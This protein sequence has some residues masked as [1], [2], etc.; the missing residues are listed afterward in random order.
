MLNNHKLTDLSTRLA[1]RRPPNPV[2]VLCKS[3]IQNWHKNCNSLREHLITSFGKLPPWLSPMRSLPGIT[4][5]K[6]ARKLCIDFDYLPY[7]CACRI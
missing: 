6:L 4:Q 2:M 7:M 1:K 3:E 5:H